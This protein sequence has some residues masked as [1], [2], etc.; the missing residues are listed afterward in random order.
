VHGYTEL[1]KYVA[2]VVILLV[3]TLGFGAVLSRWGGLDSGNA[4][5]AG[6][7][8]RPPDAQLSERLAIAY[9]A[10]RDAAGTRRLPEVRRY[11]Q[12]AVDAIAGPV[13][14]HGRPMAPPTGILPADGG[15]TVAEPGLALRA[16]DVA[17]MDS[18]LRA[19]VAGRVLGEVDGWRSPRER[20]DTIDRAV[21]DY[22]DDNGTVSALT[23][24]IE[25]ALAWALLAL[26]ADDVND[27]HDLAERGADAAKQALDAVRVARAAV[28]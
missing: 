17:A 12:V 5:P 15:Q 2:F 6:R 3:F 1:V 21:A 14:R 7:D 8:D 22:Q 28:R 16:H 20:Y 23:G 11:T 4:E 10:L 24:E 27:A 26:K 19:A 13:G 18:P 9:A 25:Q